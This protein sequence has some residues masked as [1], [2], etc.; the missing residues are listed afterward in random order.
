MR[1]ILITSAL[2]YANGPIHLGHMM[3]TYLPADV[4]SRFCKMKGYQALYVCATDEHGTPIEI[5]AAKAGKAPKDFVAE[6]HEKHK[7]S[8]ANAGIAFDEFYHTHSPENEELAVQ[9]FHEHEKKGLIYKKPIL[10]A[11]C[12]HCARFLPDRYVKGE[13][14]H[15]GAAD[16]YG[17]G[18]E[19]CGK[20]YLTTQL[21]RPKCAI[22]S[23]TPIQ[24]ETLHYFFKLHAC[25]ES[26]RKWFDENK[27]LQAEVTNY[28]KTWMESGLQDWDITRDGPYFG[29]NIPGEKDKYFYV[30]YDAPIGYASSTKHYCGSRGLDWK[31]YWQSPDCELVHFIGKDIVYHHY[32]FWPSMLSNAGLSTPMRIP[33]R[34]HLTLEGAK[35]SKSRGT[36]ITLDEF[37]A[38][39]PADYLRYYLCAV[40]PAN[41]GDAD[42]AWTEFQS[43]VNNELV[44][45]VGNFWYR[46][47]SFITTKASATI[48]APSESAKE[49]DEFAKKTDSAAHA[50]D[51][52]LEAV[53]MKTGL[54]HAMMFAAECNKYFNDRAPWSLIK[55]GKLAQ[56]E[57]VMHHSARAAYALALILHPFL[58]HSTQETFN[59]LSL[60]SAPKK[61]ND[62]SAFKP[63]LKVVGA[64][65]PFAKIE[66]EKITAKAGETKQVAE[67]I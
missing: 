66:D 55:N 26:L 40:T 19:K 56:A 62:L 47:L 5:N 13:C 8:F 46:V 44:N 42:F 59:Q 32:L 52:A 29:I 61:W 53:D 6:W 43:K 67:K 2:P 1:K 31:T 37:L 34:G 60:G 20:V 16:Q 39:F 17:D 33:T 21:N 24:K 7:A 54:E 51:A 65:I 25:T 10:Q 30:W 36:L 63:G 27:K 22:C 35:M 49:D 41:Q 15:C 3:S 50:V 14:P 57:T 9:F 48:P 38:E 58:P 11:Y 64:K 4:Y 23:S 12:E 28:L 18:C 45:S